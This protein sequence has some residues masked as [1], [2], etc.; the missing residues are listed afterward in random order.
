MIAFILSMSHVRCSRDPFK[1][2]CTP[3]TICSS[4]LR[5]LSV[6]SLSCLTYLLTVR[7]GM[8]VSSAIF[9]AFWPWKASSLICWIF[10][11]GVTGNF[12]SLLP[13]DYV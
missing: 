11:G 1:C 2:W 13:M 4:S 6:V 5:L 12:F 10:S 8:P 9:G 7:Y 3:A